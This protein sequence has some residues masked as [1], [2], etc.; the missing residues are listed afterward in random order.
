MRCLLI[1]FL[2]CSCCIS[3]KAQRVQSF[4]DNWLFWRGA[5]Q[6]AEDTLFK[7]TDWRKVSLPHD[8]SIEDL[9]GTQS[10]FS[11]GALSQVSGGF[12]T[13]GTGWYRKHFNVQLTDKGKRIV[14]QFDGVYMNAQLW[15]NG[16]KLGKHPYGYTSF[17]YDITPY[18]RYDRENI[19]TVKVRNE[20]ENSRWYAGSG[21]YRHV[22]MN[23]LE[24]V[25]VAQWG[26]FI[27]TPD[28]NKQRATV[29]ITTRVNNNT[30]TAVT[31]TLLTRV[32]D[33]KGK[34]VAANKGQQ[35][36]GAGKDSALQQS[37]IVPSPLLWDLTSPVLYTAVSYVYVDNVL[38]DSVTTPF[39]IRTI[40]AD[41]QNGFQLNGKTIKLKG[42]CVHHDNGPLGAKA[43]DRAEERK[44]ELLKSSGYNAIRC[45]HNPPSP[46]FLDACDRLGMLV[47]DEAFDIWNDGKNPEDY[48]L[49]FEE[50][51]QRDIESML[52]RDRNHPAIVMW[53]TGNEI[54]H[55]EKPEVAKVARMLR[56]HIRS[57]D[58]TRFITCGVNGIAP[59]K[60]AFLSTLDIAGYNYARTQYVKDHERVPQRV[61]MATESFAIE[62]ADYWMEVVD[63]P[64][65]I[66]DFVWTAFD[67]IGEASIGWLGYPQQ[68]SF[69]PWNLAYC[70]DI[71][72]CGWK[73][74]QSYYRDALWMP[75]QLS[76]FVKPP[77]P[78]FDTNTHK[79]EWSQWEWHDARDSW[80]WEGYE[81][82]PLDVTAYTS[83]EEA[84]LFLNGKSLGRKKAGRENK[85]M[86][87][88]QAPYSPG[89]L[90]V[91]GYNGKKKSKEVVLQ[92]AGKT[93]AIKLSADRQQVHA[94]G[95]DLSYV[96][97]TLT[98]ADGNISPDAA[99]LLQ[100]SISGPGTIV[101]VGN[102]NPMSTESCQ[103]LQRKAWRGK[104]QVIVK[105]DKQAGDIHLTVQGAGL[106]ATT[107][108]IIA[109]AK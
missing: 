15:I 87:V 109:T 82:K 16:K 5:A 51:W 96:T 68:Q 101:G 47:I 36:I 59:D 30:A 67:Y 72:V 107:M 73:R 62:A 41:A 38:K 35:L 90:S 46:A 77:V 84:E 85:F 57:I 26:T 33:A 27:T 12:T 45:S 29:N 92:T 1:V 76:L 66:G 40:T 28:V 60:D 2:V 105:A 58:I 56:D 34:I 64:W 4:D 13:G 24:P 83:Y 88:W 3:V 95:Q 42:G 21:I 69:Y 25:H 39:G 81:G 19:L 55:R 65:V 22:W 49:Y 71:D 43:Y 75:E 94:D 44:V 78:S 53:S 7:D 9:P 70:G 50:W 8:W 48:H 54:P 98:D 52:Y 10:P 97:I 32:L 99:R 86:V 102:A 37:F 17:W 100:F 108:K 79:I 20:G 31:A 93:T 11:K 91:I 80:N 103:Q 89:K 104:C 74:P 63:H 18:V 6:G 23:V 61:M 106:P 14:I